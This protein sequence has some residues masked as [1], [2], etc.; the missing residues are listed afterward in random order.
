MLAFKRSSSAAA[1]G[2][3]NNAWRIWR[4]WLGNNG[5]KTLWRRLIVKMA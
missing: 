1:N 3:I 5:V 2:V 4:K